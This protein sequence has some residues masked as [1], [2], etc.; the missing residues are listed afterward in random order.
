[1]K[2]WVYTQIFSNSVS[3]AIQTERKVKLEGFEDSKGT[4]DFIFWYMTCQI[5]SI[6]RANMVE[7]PI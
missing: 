5:H 3:A 1:M 2:V 7:M 6:W 4:C